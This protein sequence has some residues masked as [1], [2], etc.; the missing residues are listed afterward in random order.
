MFK[1]FMG[2]CGSNVQWGFVLCQFRCDARH[3]R[4][5]A[6]PAGQRIHP[7]YKLPELREAASAAAAPTEGDSHETTAVA[8]AGPSA[9]EPSK[10]RRVLVKSSEPGGPPRDT[11]DAVPPDGD[12]ARVVPD[13]AVAADG[14]TLWHFTG[15][16]SMHAFWVVDR[17][18]EEWL[19]ILRSHGKGVPGRPVQNAAVAAAKLE[20]NCELQDTHFMSMVVGSIGTETVNGSLQVTIP[21]L[22]NTIDLKKGDFLLMEVGKKP[23]GKK[24]D[25]TWKTDAERAVQNAKKACAAK[26]S[27]K[28][29]T[30]AHTSTDAAVMSF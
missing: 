17:A 15:Q 23:S 19:G 9:E 4:W 25:H 16:E 14:E 1:L 2:S 13:A 26:P 10:R 7:Q 21:I 3:T 5:P 20:F 18:T 24:R 12:A 27:A 22:T 29:K 30:T 11:A 28:K 8:V 6:L